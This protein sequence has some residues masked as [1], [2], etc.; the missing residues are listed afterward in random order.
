MKKWLDQYYSV[1]MMPVKLGS[2][3]NQFFGH[4]DMNSAGT[5]TGLEILTDC[6][7]ESNANGG[8]EFSKIFQNVSH[9]HLIY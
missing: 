3:I 4:D 7:H 5:A 9:W 2:Q 1:Q 8:L 6:H